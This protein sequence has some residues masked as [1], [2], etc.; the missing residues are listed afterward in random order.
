[1]RGAG[2]G[3]LLLIPYFFLRAARYV[4]IPPEKARQYLMYECLMWRRLPHPV[5]S[6]KPGEEGRCVSNRQDS[7]KRF[8]PVR[9]GGGASLWD[10]PD[11]RVHVKGRAPVAGVDV[12]A[13]REASPNGPPG[14]GDARFVRLEALVRAGYQR[15]PANER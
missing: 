1:M 3:R 8:E 9:R 7:S 6:V 5:P 12:S 14:S 13:T 4:T 2:A 10:Q 11:E 15:N